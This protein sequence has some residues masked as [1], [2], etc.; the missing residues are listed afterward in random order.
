LLATWIADT[1]M[2]IERANESDLPE[3]LRL[4]EHH[5]LPIEGVR[6]HVRS[7]VVARDNGR[8]VGVAGA[9][10]YPDGALLRSVA[11]ESALQG[12]GVGHLLTEAVLRMARDHE[13]DTV[14]LLTTTAEAFFPRFG[15]ERITRNEVPAMVQTSIEFRSECPTS[16]VVMRKR[17]VRDE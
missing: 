16:A 8:V 6:D 13:V 14:F 10:F 15:F 9:E 4:L 2:V 5:R 12:K 17:V 1:P 3:V 11:V 7:M